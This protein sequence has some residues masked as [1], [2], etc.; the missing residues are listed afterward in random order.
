M[1]DIYSK[2]GRSQKGVGKHKLL[3]KW[4]YMQEIVDCKAEQ[5]GRKG[6]Q[7][8]VFSTKG[9]G[10]KPKLANDSL[11]DG[12]FVNRNEFVRR[13]MDTGRDL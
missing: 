9:R 10:R 2:R 8:G 4:R 7:S 13:T 6:K 11:S 1:V 5:S 3:K 12:D